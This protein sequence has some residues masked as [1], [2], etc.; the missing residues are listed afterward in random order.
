MPREGYRM[1]VLAPG[2]YREVLNSDAAGWGGNMGNAGGV[3][4]EPF[5]R[6]RWCT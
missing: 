3:P 6:W 1:G 5:R 4:A 2:V